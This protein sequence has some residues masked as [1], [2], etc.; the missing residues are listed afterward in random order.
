MVD[1]LL[2]GTLSKSATPGMQSVVELTFECSDDLV[3]ATEKLDR[4][5]TD[6]SSL[7]EPRVAIVRLQP[8]SSVSFAGTRLTTHAAGRWERA[9]R[10]FERLDAVGITVAYGVCGG[11]SLDLLL[12][13][14]CRIASQ[15]CQLKLP[16]CE[17][18]F[19][20]GMAMYR[21]A[22]Q[23]GLAQARRIVFQEQQID[24][25]RCIEL[26]LVDPSMSDIDT[27]LADQL[28]KLTDVS[29][30]D[31]AIRRRLLQ[32]AISTSYED[33]LGTHLAACDRTLKR[34]TINDND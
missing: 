20:P 9:V 25:S 2:V 16:R 21:L 27:V 12:V 24:R 22:Q 13:A 4:L 29:T 18:Q 17:G 32:E 34:T 31:L 10:R 19:W 3:R 7:P 6:I 30:S 33:A 5:C 11:I 28:A 14:D 1:N 26:G 15:D 23:V 8:D